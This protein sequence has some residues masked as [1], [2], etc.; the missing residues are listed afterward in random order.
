MESAVLACEAPAGGAAAPGAGGGGG[1][2]DVVMLKRSVLAACLT[3]PLCGRLLRDAATITE[4]LHTCEYYS[5]LRQPFAVLDRFYSLWLMST[6]F[7]YRIDHSL[8]YVRSKIFPKKQ[9]VEAPEVTSPVTSPIKRKERSL[10]SLT[11]HAP[12]VSMQKCL[13][14]RRTKASCLHNLSLHSKLR[15]SITKKAGGWRPLGS[16]FK[17]AKNKR[18]LRSKSEDVNAT[19]NKSDDPVDGTLTSQAKTK[20]QYTRRGN[21]EKRTGSKKLLISKGK[22]KKVKPKLPNKKRKLRA[23]WFH[24]VAAFDQKGEPPL[25]QVPTKFLRI[26]DVDLPAS[27][28]QKYL[29]QKLNLSSEA[30]VDIL[31]G[32]KPVSPGMTLHDLADCWL[33]RGQK[34]RVQSSVGTPAAG[35]IA[36]VFYGRSG[37]SI[38]E[39]ENNQG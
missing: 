28:I 13:T 4:C 27:F 29:V 6:I 5:L 8:Q 14:K 25:P 23:L 34:G 11:I 3:C 7:R 30:E 39:T 35:F 33:D 17:A 38:P 1:A 20:R 16:H 18:S 26:R 19:E 10:S 32:G 24:L 15:G 22:Q 9:K 12:Q 31:C 36:K 2:G 37:A 21:L